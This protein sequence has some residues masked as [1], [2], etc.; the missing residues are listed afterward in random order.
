MTPFHSPVFRRSASNGVD[1]RWTRKDAP[2]GQESTNS[3][4]LDHDPTHGITRDTDYQVGWVPEHD[5]TGR[6]R[7]REATK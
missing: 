4:N 2:K 7:P 5:L 3:G 6:R 1:H